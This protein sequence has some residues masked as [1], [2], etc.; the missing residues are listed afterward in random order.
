MRPGVASRSPEQSPKGDVTGAVGSLPMGDRPFDDKSS[1]TLV[2]GPWRRALDGE[3]DSPSSPPHV[4]PFARITVACPS[5][6]SSLPMEC[7]ARWPGGGQRHSS[8]LVS[9]RAGRSFA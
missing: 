5:M 7:I 6:G 9:A 8:G 1:D 2:V 3:F 4:L